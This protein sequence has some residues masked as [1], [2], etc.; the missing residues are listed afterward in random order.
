MKRLTTHLSLYTCL[1]F[2]PQLSFAD[3]PNFK[4][5]AVSAGWLHVMPQGKANNMNI[6]TAVQEGGNYGVGRL[7]NEDLANHSNLQQ[8]IDNNE[9]PPLAA[10]VAP[11]ILDA[12]KKNPSGYVPSFI[13]DGARADVYGISNWSDQ[14][15]L[16][17]QN[18]D[19]LGL[20]LSYFVS[21]KVSVEVIGGIPPTVDINGKGKIVARAHAVANTP[22]SGGVLDI[23]PMINGMELDKDILITDLTAHGKVAEARAWTP[24]VTARYHFGRS[25][26]DKFRPY[27]GAGIVY[28]YFDKLKISSGLEQDLVNAGH[29]VQNVLDGQAGDALQNTGK[30]SANPAVDVDVDDTFGAVVTAGFSYDFNERWFSTASVTYMP[31]FN[32][33]AKISIV[34]A[35]SG[36]QLIRASTKIDLDPLITYLGVGYRF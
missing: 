32:S 36:N 13:T 27:L 1:L 5:W 24:A 29:M 18:A 28:G 21:D 33:T 6:N 8:M 23:P 17:A 2:I 11:A 7:K 22:S 10:L 15:G 12:A 34:D 35:N 3:N 16:E 14:A 19:T 31:K 9:L 30:S 4:R 20:T 25:G 26:V